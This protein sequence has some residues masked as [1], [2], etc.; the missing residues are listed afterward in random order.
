MF[1]SFNQHTQTIT[2]DTISAIPTGEDLKSLLGVEDME[3]ISSAIAATSNN[4]HN[5]NKQSDS[6]SLHSTSFTS[7]STSHHNSATPI[8]TDISNPSQIA[9]FLHH[10]M[11]IFDHPTNTPPSSSLSSSSSSSSSS[12]TS[13]STTSTEMA[14]ARRA[15]ESF[16]CWGDDYTG[17][18]DLLMKQTWSPLLNPLLVT[19]HNNNSRV[20]GG[21]LSQQQQ[22]QEALPVLVY[23]MCIR[24]FQL[25][26]TLGYYF[27]DIACAQVRTTNK[28]E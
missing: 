4:I 12:T 10:V 23:P 6:S 3:T 15:A 2:H 5:N 21:L 24:T 13:T 20:G 26:N 18:R 17:S 1:F 14:A 28:Y 27:N 9:T 7:T 11:D 25:G 22:Q 16:G 8:L 19:D